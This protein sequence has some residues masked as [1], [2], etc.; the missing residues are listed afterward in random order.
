MPA[1]D[2]L[3]FYL[4]SPALP[5]STGQVIESISKAGCHFGILPELL[6]PFFP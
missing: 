1:P 3:F 6:D 5:E 4:L 2:V